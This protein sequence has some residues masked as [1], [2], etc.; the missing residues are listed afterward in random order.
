[1]GAYYFLASQLPYLIYGQTPP[2]SSE[3]FKELAKPLLGTRDAAL[4]D[5]VSPD[6]YPAEL[7]AEGPS[8]FKS[9][10]SSGSDFIDKWR[11]WERALRLNLAR[12]RASKLNW[13]GAAPVDAPT[14]PSEAVAAASRVMA[15][16]DSPL[17]AELH[18]DRERW[19]VIE[20]LQ[21]MDTFSSNSIFAYLLKL[22][23][24]ERH[25]SFQTE[26]GF[27]EYKSLYA[28]IV[29]SVVNNGDTK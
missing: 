1:M 14:E 10:P 25:A 28:S 15:S 11:D 7:C 9:A 26:K 24:L 8:Y 27:I 13:E 20:A 19:D 17:E 16:Y 2:M 12:H 3:A 4:L 22:M 29:G 18:L 21:G 6:P 23:L 5:I